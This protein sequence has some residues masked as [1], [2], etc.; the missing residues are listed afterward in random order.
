MKT[1][2]KT[3]VVKTRA[4]DHVV[5]PTA[6][7]ERARARLQAIGFIVAAVGVH[8]FGTENA[9]VFFADGTFLEPLAIGHRETAEAASMAGNQFISRDA[10]YRFRRGVEGFSSIVMASNDANADAHQFNASGMS[11]GNVLEFGREFVMPSGEKSRMEFRLAFAA[12]LRSPDFFGITCER[13]NVPK[14]DRSQLTGHA[15][16][17]TALKTIVLTETNPTDFQY[18]FQELINQREVE[19]HS[20]G[21]ELRASNATISILTPDGFEMFFGGH[22]KTDARG[23]IARALVFS[24]PDL[25]MVAAIL[26]ENAITFRH[27]LGRLIVEAAEGQGAMFVFEASL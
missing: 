24:C 8:P 2:E 18:L 17:V 14:A 26:S 23:L 11:G 20:F 7:L 21:M 22:S 27:H 5:L 9:C 1:L 10:A 25:N 6:S 4:L 13:I 16:G 15:N 19:A 12:D 3:A